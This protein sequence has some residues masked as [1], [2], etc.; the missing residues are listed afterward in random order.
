M[1]YALPLPDYILTGIAPN[2][3]MM[4]TGD[5]NGRCWLIARRLADRPGQGEP[6]VWTQEDCPQTASIL[7]PS[8]GLGSLGSDLS[9]NC[10][11]EADQI[12]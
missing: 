5:P 3:S 7:T 1:G 4:A 6:G 9:A 8:G 11:P 10:D 12:R 2:G